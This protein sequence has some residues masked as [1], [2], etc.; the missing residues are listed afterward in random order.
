LS[1]FFHLVILGHS[2][3]VGSNTESIEIEL[4]AFV[5]GENFNHSVLSP[6]LT[7]GILDE[8]K[9]LTIVL[10]VPSNNFYY[11][12]SIVLFGV[13][14]AMVD[15]VL[16]CQEVCENSHLCNNRAVFENLLF[17]TNIF[18]GKTVV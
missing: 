5:G 13:I 2:V 12:L 15:T 11:M 16:V 8:P 10:L 4:C 14:G 1:H 6:I 17:N 7:P 9:L 18:L 3:G